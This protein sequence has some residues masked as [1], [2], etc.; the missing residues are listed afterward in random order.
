M[1][2]LLVSR[3]LPAPREILWKYVSTALGLSSWQADSVEGGLD[4]GTFQLRWPELGAR[5][6]L[7][8]DEV[9]EG[10]RLTLRTGD[11][12]LRMEVGEGRIQLAHE[13]LQPDDDLPGLESSWH[14]ALSLLSIATSRH[15]EK[16]RSVRW[17]FRPI[18]G[19]AEL[20]H[21][22][23]TDPRGLAPWLGASAVGLTEGAPVAIE[24]DKKERITGEVLAA[25]RDVC[26]RVDQINNGALVLRT[27]PGP[28]DQRIVA[29][30]ISVWG[31]TPND[32]FIELVE[33]ALGRLARIVQTPAN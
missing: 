10:R 26:L 27:L 29:A 7:D 1:K 20:A 18:T 14:T 32:K 33:T 21:Y 12:R 3:N 13:G 23:F 2:P 31:G 28:E 9:D 24:F 11:T 22:Y 5:M 8:V 19:S 30:G 6:D 15:Q 17:L 25:G 4:E 16:K